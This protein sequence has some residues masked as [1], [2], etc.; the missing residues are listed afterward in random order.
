M[1][2]AITEINPKMAFNDLLAEVIYVSDSF[3]GFFENMLG[4]DE[5]KNIGDVT[6]N[7]PEDNVWYGMGA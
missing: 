4:I 2:E 3:N 5:V 1:W 6:L 7:D